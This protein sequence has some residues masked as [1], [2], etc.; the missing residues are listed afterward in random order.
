MSTVNRPLSWLVL[1]LCCSCAPSHVT[2]A[3][4]GNVP[5]APVASV[6]Q[7][8]ERE[9]P[10]LGIAGVSDRSVKPKL[11][12]GVAS[13]FEAKGWFG[14]YE[15]SKLLYCRDA[16]RKAATTWADA[17]GVVEALVDDKQE[18]RLMLRWRAPKEDGD[19]VLVYRLFTEPDNYHA[20]SLNFIDRSAKVVPTEVMAD[21]LRE[22]Y[23]LRPLE[24]TLRETLRCA[25]QFKSAEE[26][27]R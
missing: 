12:E 25:E 21:E 10:L 27:K 4:V 11:W 23:E 17:H 18:H 26:G 9:V 24:R 14:T 3:P 15:Y 19:F 5:A 13:G 6:S 22:R 20:T 8:D 16:V 2:P 7:R 1:L